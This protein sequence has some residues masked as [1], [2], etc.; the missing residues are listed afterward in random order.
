MVRFD[1]NNDY[2][3]PFC[4]LLLVAYCCFRLEAF[5][6]CLL[7]MNK[8]TMCLHDEYIGPY[9]GF[10]RLMELLTFILNENNVIHGITSISRVFVTSDGTAIG[11][12]HRRW[13]HTVCVNNHLCWLNCRAY[14]TFSSLT[15]YNIK[16]SHIL[17]TNY[18]I[19]YKYYQR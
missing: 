12:C 19:K 15:W 10:N 7:H 18:F 9:K 2:W 17:K 5:T 8:V 6:W 4:C 13:M 3:R 1:S 14:S 16:K 11:R